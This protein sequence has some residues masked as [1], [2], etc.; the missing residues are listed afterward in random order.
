MK[1]IFYDLDEW[2]DLIEESKPK[3]ISEGAKWW[4]SRIKTK[5]SLSFS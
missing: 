4:L 1:G 5:T 3:E 2:L